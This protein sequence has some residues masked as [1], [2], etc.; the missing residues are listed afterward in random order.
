MVWVVGEGT[1]RYLITGKG[2]RIAQE[3]QQGVSGVL[4][5][6]NPLSPAD[7]AWW[8]FKRYSVRIPSRADRIAQCPLSVPSVPPM[9]PCG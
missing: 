9:Y 2:L 3:G 7:G 6:E 5:P 1:L 8:G 4:V